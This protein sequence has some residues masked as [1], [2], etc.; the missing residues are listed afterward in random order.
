MLRAIEEFVTG[1]TTA[2]VPDRLLTTVVF[3]NVFGAGAGA[4]GFRDAVSRRVG[5]HTAEVEEC[6]DDIAGVGVHVGAR[7]AAAATRVKSG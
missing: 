4:A 5:I 2:S 3:V 7:V 6:G 1:S